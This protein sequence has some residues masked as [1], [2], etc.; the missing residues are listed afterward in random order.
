LSS[1]APPVVTTAWPHTIISPQLVGVKPDALKQIRDG[2]PTGDTDA[3]VCFVRKLARTSGTV[4]DEDFAAIKAAS[5][6]DAQLVET[7]LAFATTVFPNIFNRIND[8]EIDFL[9]V[10]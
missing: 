5:Y 7:S 3:L 6:S 10:A 9:A 2:N 1:A 8:T 4:S